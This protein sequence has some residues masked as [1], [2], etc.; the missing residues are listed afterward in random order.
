MTIS[1]HFRNI[2]SIQKFWPGPH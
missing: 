2:W 1:K